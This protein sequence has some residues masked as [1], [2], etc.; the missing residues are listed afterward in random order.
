M[1]VPSF[2][3]PSKDANP[4]GKTPQPHTYIAATSQGR[5]LRLALTIVGGRTHLTAR[6]FAKPQTGLVARLLPSI[7]NTGAT[8]PTDTE[9]TNALVLGSGLGGRHVWALHETRIQRW[10]LSDAGWEEIVLDED[11]TGLVKEALRGAFATAPVDDSQLG[12]ELLDLAIA[13]CVPC[14]CYVCE[15]FVS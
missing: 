11:V 14:V 1:C 12:L 4:R 3:H 2:L 9:A 7:W 8:L 10:D 13:E 6:A 15:G 5:I